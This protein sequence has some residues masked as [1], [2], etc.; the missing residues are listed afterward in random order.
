[1]YYC[2]DRLRNV[3]NC[4]S[5][6]AGVLEAGLLHHVALLSP[7]TAALDDQGKT[8]ERQIDSLELEK[9]ALSERLRR[10]IAVAA[11]TEQPIPELTLQINTLQAGINEAD[12]KMVVARNLLIDLQNIN[13]D[14]AFDSMYTVLR[15]GTDEQRSALRERLLRLITHVEVHSDELYLR[16]H[17]RIY[18]LAPLVVPLSNVARIP[19]CN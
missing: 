3:T 1:M 19:G 16:I 15:D 11:G 5:I 6:K 4:A 14:D 8:L 18:G 9:K 17:S 13:P 7:S 10:L 2:A 12:A